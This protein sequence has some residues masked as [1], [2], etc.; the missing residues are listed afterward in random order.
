MLA[1][2]A[3][4]RPAGAGTR[5]V[6]EANHRDPVMTSHINDRKPGSVTTDM[7]NRNR[8]L[9]KR[10][11]GAVTAGSGQAARRARPVTPARF[12][13]MVHRMVPAH[14]ACRT[15]ARARAGERDPWPAV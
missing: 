9:A 5:A 11:T 1:G 7:T 15:G 4:D 3:G 10:E 8:D 6:N 2:R 12:G 13:T 14:L